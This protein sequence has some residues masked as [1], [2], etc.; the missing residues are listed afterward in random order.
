MEVRPTVE[1]MIL[2]LL[3]NARR[4]ELLKSNAATEGEGV[5]GAANV[6]IVLIVWLTTKKERKEQRV[7][8]GA[9]GA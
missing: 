8:A 5:H 2:P 3:T 9:S 6:V 1:A 4:V 7:T